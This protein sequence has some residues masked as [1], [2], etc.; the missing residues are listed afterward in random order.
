[1][2]IFWETIFL[3]VVPIPYHDR[4]ILM[5]VEGQIVCYFL[6]DFLMAFMWIRVYNLIRTIM[7]STIYMNPFAKKICNQYGFDSGVKFILK[8]YINTM[9]EFT[10]L[11]IFFTTVFIAAYLIRIFELPYYRSMNQNFGYF[12]SV[13]LTVITLTTVGYGDMFAKTIPGRLVT[14]AL[15]LWGTVLISLMVVVFSGIFELDKNQQLAVNH[16]KVMQTAAATINSSIGYFKAKR[17][18]RMLKAQ[19]E[20]L[21]H[22][23]DTFLRGIKENCQSFEKKIENMRS[24]VGS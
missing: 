5:N 16:I 18:K 24:F 4:Y 6:S 14:M 23:Q 11:T 22:S 13:W 17:H 19:R 1:M 8:A 20:G 15:A 9:P 7:N 2:V 3:V 12:D 21:D 10:V